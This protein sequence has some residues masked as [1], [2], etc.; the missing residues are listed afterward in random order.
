MHLTLFTLDEANQAV[1]DIGPE[2]EAMVQARRELERIQ[3]AIDVLELTMAGA[4][5]RNPDARELKTHAARKQTLMQ[6]L[7]HGVERIQ[8]R[9]CVLKD[10]EQGLVDFYA[11]DGDRLVFLC[12]RLGEP[13]VAHWHTLDGGFASRRPVHGRKDQE[14]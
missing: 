8:R 11:L 4:D 2:L 1:R 13:D 5:E 14:S 12:W 9:G 10:L 3:A 6:R 7:R